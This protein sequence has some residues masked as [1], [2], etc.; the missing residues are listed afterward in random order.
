M[1]ARKLL[2]LHPGV[3][4]PNVA[5][6]PTIQAGGQ[7]VLPLQLNLPIRSYLPIGPWGNAL[8]CQEQL[9]WQSVIIRLL[10]HGKAPPSGKVHFSSVPRKGTL[11]PDTKQG[12]TAGDGTSNVFTHSAVLFLS[13]GITKIAALTRLQ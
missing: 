10:P 1:S 12:L 3:L 9:F 13:K 8:P 5:G 2:D 6:D 4:K 11:P 7:I